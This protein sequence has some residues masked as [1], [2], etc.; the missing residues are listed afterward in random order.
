MEL[1]C[2]IIF[3]SNSVVTKVNYVYVFVVFM[4]SHGD[5]VD[6]VVYCHFRPLLG[7][8]DD[9]VVPDEGSGAIDVMDM[10]MFALVRF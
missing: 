6:G 3:R 5:G 10:H 2:S 9:L 1:N 7:R 8:N 4:E